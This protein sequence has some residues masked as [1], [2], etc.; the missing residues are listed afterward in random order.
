MKNMTLVIDP[1]KEDRFYLR[2]RL[3]LAGRTLVH[4]AESALQ[5]LDFVRQHYFDLVIVNLQLPDMAGW[6]LV[7]QLVALEPQVG[8]VVVT[9]INGSTDMPDL[10]DEAGCRDFL[11][12]PF[13]PFKVQAVLL[14]I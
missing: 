4:E 11:E 8:A 13:D 12:K 7:R 2:A 14:K 1:S 5:G 6:E 10:A 3:A 9:T